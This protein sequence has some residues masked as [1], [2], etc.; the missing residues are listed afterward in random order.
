MS[1]FLFYIFL[2]IISFLIIYMCCGIAPR[3]GAV[4]H[5]GK[6]SMSDLNKAMIIGRLGAGIDDTALGYDTITTDSGNII[7]KGSCA[8]NSYWD[9]DGGERMQ[10][11]EWHRWVAFDREATRIS[12]AELRKGLK[13]YIEGPLKTSSW[14]DK[15]T[16]KKMYKT[17]I[18]V[19]RCEFLEPREHSGYE[20]HPKYHADDGAYQV[21][22]D[23]VSQV[24]DSKGVFYNQVA[25]IESIQ[26]DLNDIE[27]Q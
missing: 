12:N 25:D 14:E 26:E 21:D 18:I 4:S 3:T 8:T 23:E 10:R 6:E 1:L 22:S 15:E 20:D 2:F 5:H 13:V 19:R 11:T 9:T 16:G 24:P 27:K 17:E 7:C